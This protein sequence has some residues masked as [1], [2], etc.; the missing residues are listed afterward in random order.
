M[1]ITLLIALL[2]SLPLTPMPQSQAGVYNSEIWNAWNVTPQNELP[3]AEWP[4]SLHTDVPTTF[5]IYT[6]GKRF[7]G[8]AIVDECPG[9]GDLKNG[10]IDGENVSFT[11]IARTDPFTGQAIYYSGKIRGNEMDLT[12][13]WDYGSQ[14]PLELKIKARKFQHE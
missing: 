1:F 2:G 3:Q 6:D 9:D 11:V 13:R 12:M 14:H 10:T 5:L 8:K 4:I 7:G